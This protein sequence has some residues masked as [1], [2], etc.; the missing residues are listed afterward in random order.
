MKRKIAEKEAKRRVREANGTAS[1]QITPAALVIETRVADPPAH[2]SLP[3]SVNGPG[4]SGSVASEG[5]PSA[6][7][8]ARNEERARLEARRNELHRQLAGESGI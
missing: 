6:A 5:P 4:R 1:G 3:G 8:R 2:I 7:A